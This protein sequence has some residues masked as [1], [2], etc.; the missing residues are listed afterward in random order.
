MTQKLPFIKANT[1]MWD[2]TKKKLGSNNFNT[3]Q[4]DLYKEA[5]N[6]LNTTQQDLY[7]EVYQ[8]KI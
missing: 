3:T 8:F 6:N 4:Q 5:C 1:S 7:K 2:K